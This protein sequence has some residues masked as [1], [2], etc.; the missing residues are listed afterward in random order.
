MPGLIVDQSPFVSASDVIGRHQ[1]V[2]WTQNE[3][4]SVARRKFER[5]RKRYYVLRLRRIVPIERRMRRGLFEMD[6]YDV[7]AIVLGNHSLQDV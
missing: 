5:P 2:A 3:S 6:C 1:H 4:L 7:A